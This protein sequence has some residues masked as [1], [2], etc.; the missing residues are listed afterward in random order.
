MKRA[1]ITGVT[2]QD[3]AYLSKLLLEK[4][5]EV[6]GGFS[7][8]GPVDDS[9]LRMLNVHNA[10]H[11]V[12][13]ELL[14]PE[15]VVACLTSIQPDEVYNL[16]A[17]SY[18]VRSFQHPIETLRVNGLGVAHILEAIRTINPAIRFYQASSSE[19]FGK[20]HEVPQR[21][22][23]FFHP[24]SPYAVSKL[25]GHWIT[26]NY[27]EA[28]G[29]PAC[30]GIL[31]NHESPLRGKEFVTRKITR[32]LTAIRH[33]RQDCLELGNV[34]A[35]RDWGF[36]G[37]YV[38]GM[39]LML[40]QEPHAFD[41]FIL[42]TGETHSIREF[43]EIAGRYHGFDVVWEGSG[44]HEVGRD[45]QTHRTIIRINPQLFRPAEVDVVVGDASKARQKLGWHPTV[46]FEQ[47]VLMLAKADDQGESR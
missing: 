25:Y 30:C 43:V 9:G 47:L 22:S 6:Y 8:T 7:T 45:R 39:W 12:P 3:G 1:L 16:A 35:K 24:R 34:N 29:I 33:G 19:M 31:F 4:G 26:I 40:Q 21:E 32:G 15:S 17:Q 42:A 10:L 5:Y 13:C 41:D 20:A 37:D 18:V 28:Y 14:D 36:A 23:T 46:S 11:L 38:Y 27:R 2:G 44:E